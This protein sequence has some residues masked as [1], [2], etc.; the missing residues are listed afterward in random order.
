MFSRL[1]LP[2]HLNKSAR[3]SSGEGSKASWQYTY[4]VS[5]FKASSQGN[6]KNASMQKQL[7]WHKE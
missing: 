2:K 1:P 5:T 3:H 6:V 4:S 7:A